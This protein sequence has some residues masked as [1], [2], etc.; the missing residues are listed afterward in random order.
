[1]EE[2]ISM[3]IEDMSSKKGLP[4]DYAN[5]ALIAAIFNQAIVDCCYK[6]KDKDLIYERGR[7]LRFISNPEELDFIMYCEFLDLEPNYVS[8]RLCDFVKNNAGTK[9]SKEIKNRIETMKDK[10]MSSLNRSEPKKKKKKKHP[11][12]SLKI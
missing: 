5:R 1:M 6:G 4:E 12:S 9:V 10:G 7:A 11:W 8:K 2:F 3:Q